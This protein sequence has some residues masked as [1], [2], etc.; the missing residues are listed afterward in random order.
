M[1]FDGRCKSDSCY[2]KCVPAETRFRDTNMRSMKII[3]FSRPPTPLSI[4]IQNSST[5]LTLDVQFQT[6]P[7]PSSTSYLHLSLSA[8]WWHN[9]LVYV[10][11]QKYHEMFFL[12]IITHVF[13]V[14]FAINLFY[15]HNFKT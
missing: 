13:S 11:V 4:Y 6:N 12:F 3:Q 2:P 5:S 7:P 10:V 1:V 9:T 14:H 8:F 15:L